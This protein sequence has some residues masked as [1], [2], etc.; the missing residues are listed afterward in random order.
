M[1]DLDNKIRQT[2]SQAA[3]QSAFPPDPS[4]ED[5]ILALFQ[6]RRRWLMIWGGIK[7]IIAAVLIC[8][9]MVM[10]FQQTTTMGMIGYASATIVCTVGYAAVALALWIQINHNNTDRE[11]KRLELQIS[12]LNQ[13]LEQP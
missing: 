6:G 4:F 10:F 12:I 7:M 5:E 2:L 1:N 9:C 13:R 11:I 3:D 8:F